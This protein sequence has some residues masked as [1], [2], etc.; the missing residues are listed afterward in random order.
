MFSTPQELQTDLMPVKNG[1][2]ILASQ[3]VLKSPRFLGLL[4]NAVMLDRDTI[5]YET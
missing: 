2:K 3:A 4:D 5:A 1:D